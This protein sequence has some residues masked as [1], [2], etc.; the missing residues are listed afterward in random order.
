MNLVLAIIYV[1]DEHLSKKY[2]FDKLD[3]FIV[4]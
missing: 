2:I 1:S 3:D 4:C